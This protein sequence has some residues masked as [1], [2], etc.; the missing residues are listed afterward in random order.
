VERSEGA[1][2]DVWLRV[3]LRRGDVAIREG[4]KKEKKK[5][6]SIHLDKKVRQQAIKCRVQRDI[7]K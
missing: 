6:A 3:S 4:K 7:S 2:R 5:S 1:Q